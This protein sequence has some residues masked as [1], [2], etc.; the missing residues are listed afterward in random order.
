MTLL[1]SKNVKDIKVSILKALL[2]LGCNN[3]FLQL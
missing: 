2:Q 3:D 1:T